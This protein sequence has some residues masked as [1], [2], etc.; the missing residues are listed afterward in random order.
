VPASLAS[1]DHVHP[2]WRPYQELSDE[3]IARARVI[4]VAPEA[5][6]VVPP[7]PSWAEEFHRIEARIRSALGDRALII[8]HVGSTSVPGLWAKNVI[9]VDLTVPDSGDEATY[10]PAMEAAGFVLRAREPEWEEH[11]MFRGSDPMSNV[12]VW[13]PGAVEPRRTRMFRDWLRTHDDDRAA[14]ADLKRDLAT[15][16]FVDVMHYN[17]AKAGL[18]YDIYERIFAA[19]PA[20]EHDPR[21][22]T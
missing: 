11:R 13:S 2:L 17:N 19:D 3:E 16:G 21:P 18:I 5:V 10:V 14:Y 7:D 22:R 1:V 8:E 4:P 20:H 6:E 12:H 15:R 9:D